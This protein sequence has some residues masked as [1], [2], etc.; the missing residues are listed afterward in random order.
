MF[1]QFCF[2][3]NYLLADDTASRQILA[4]YYVRMPNDVI[5]RIPLGNRKNS[6]SEPP[7]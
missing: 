7:S 4:L 5:L 3:Q 6:K 2:I 1:F